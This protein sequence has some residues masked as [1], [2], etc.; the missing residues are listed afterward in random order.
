[1]V[2]GNAAIATIPLSPE[3]GLVCLVQST[4]VNIRFLL[5]I[6]KE[7]LEMVFGLQTHVTSNKDNVLLVKPNTPQTGCSP[8]P[9]QAVFS[10]RLIT[11]YFILQHAPQV[12]GPI[13][14]DAP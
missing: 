3:S 13:I 6:L 1:M 2:A 8:R 10:V 12:M 7:V 4:A 14:L 9:G 11:T 5:T